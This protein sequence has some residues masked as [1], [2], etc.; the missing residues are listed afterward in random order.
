M[1]QRATNSPEKRNAAY[2]AYEHAIVLAPTIALTYRRYADFAL[3]AGD[4][5][6]AL[7]LAQKAIDLD[8]TDGV[9][10]AILGWAQL[11]VGNLPVAQDA[12][13][14]AVR[15]SPTS[16]DIY[17]GLAT[18]HLQQGNLELA[19]ATLKQGLGAQS[20]LFPCLD[21]T[22]TIKCSYTMNYHECLSFC[23]KVKLVTHVKEMQIK[24]EAMRSQNHNATSSVDHCRTL[25]TWWDWA[26]IG[27]AGLTLPCLRRPLHRVKSLAM[28]LPIKGIS[29]MPPICPLTGTFNMRFEIYN[30]PTG[31]DPAMG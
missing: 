11:R 30:A 15:W 13:A 2:R 31:G 21:I 3:R 23:T 24:G 6:H 19:R 8:A 25:A 7:A 14:Q 12:F 10:F 5:A 1:R 22:G 28:R 9:A 17:V 26:R 27:R 20:Y 16:A 29:P 18:V 4:H